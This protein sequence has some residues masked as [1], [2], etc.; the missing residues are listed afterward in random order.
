MP[1][2]CAYDAAHREQH[3]ESSDSKHQSDTINVVIKTTAHHI[4]EAHEVFTEDF[5]VHTGQNTILG[6]SD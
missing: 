6:V 4:F 5:A 3:A 2:S 1:Y